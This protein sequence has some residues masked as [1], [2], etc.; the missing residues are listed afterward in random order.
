[1]ASF[2][3]LT[4]S[5][6]REENIE[7]NQIKIL[8]EKSAKKMSLKN[9][10]KEGKDK[11]ILKM[12]KKNRQSQIKKATKKKLKLQKKEITSKVDYSIIFIIY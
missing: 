12:L 11:K 10:K 1:M 9:K 8:I 7:E 5:S 6:P 2:K 3:V 4:T